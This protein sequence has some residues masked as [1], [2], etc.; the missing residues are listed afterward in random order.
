VH[1]NGGLKFNE[2]AE[3]RSV[4][5]TRMNLNEVR[6][7]QRH[8]G[9]NKFPFVGIVGLKFIFFSLPENHRSSY[10]RRHTSL[11]ADCE[12]R[13]EVACWKVHLIHLKRVE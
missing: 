12:L 7:F 1:E 2:G 11:A 9:G 13:K 5:Q 4:W 3:G 6:R 8:S 10:F